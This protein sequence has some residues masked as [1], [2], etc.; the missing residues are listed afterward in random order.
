MRATVHGLGVLLASSALTLPALADD[1]AGA[2]NSPFKA[3]ITRTTHNIAHIEADTWE[4]VGYGVAYAYAED[5]ICMLAEDFVSVRGERSM[6]FGNEGQNELGLRSMD[7]LT[8]DVFFRSQVDLPALRAGLEQ[9]SPVNQALIAGYVAGYNRYLF[10]NPV[11][12]LPK[13]CRDAPWVRPITNDDMLRL[14]EKT[15]LLASSLAFA[16]AIAGAEPPSGGQASN[17]TETLNFPPPPEPSYGSNGWAFGSDVTADGKGLLIG[18]P[19]FPWEGP[20]RFWQMHVRGPDGYDVMGVGIAGTPLP[21]LGFNKDVAWTHTVTKARHFTAYMLQLAP[22]DPTSYIVDGEVVPMEETLVTIPMPVGEEPIERVMYST[23]FG[24]V[25]T[26]PQAGAVWTRQ[27]AFT[28][29]DA[30]T[31]NQRGMDAWLGIG[32]ASNVSEIETAI[33]ETL[34]IP[35]VNTIAADRNGNALHA[36]ITAVPNVS[37]EMAKECSTP[38]SALVAGQITLLDGT[39]SQCD[40]M[41]APT[42]ASVPGLLPASEQASRTRTDYVTNSNDSYW[43]SHAGEPYRELSP[44]LG[45]YKTELTLRSRSN[46]TETEATLAEA[47]IDHARAKELVFGNKV[48]AADMVVDGV[49]EECSEKAGLSKACEV[50]ADWDRRVNLD[51]KGAHLFLAFWDKVRGRKDLWA[52][53]FDPE[54]PVNTPRDLTSEGTVRLNLY[55]ALNE[56]GSELEE[57]GI[58]LDAPWGM[59]QTRMDGDETIPIHGATGL[60]GILNMQ[61][62]REVEGGLTPVHGSSYIQ[63]VGFDTDGPVADA[64]LSYSQSTNPASPFYA[65]QTRL[66]SAKDWHRLPF[67]DEEIEAARIGETVTISE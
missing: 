63:I 24:P 33:S 52:T 45:T 21:T 55:K 20:A 41:E 3:E 10:D 58:P 13:E 6:F 49:V 44:I 14:N 26:M 36:D 48:L 30:N 7:N 56:A 32:K 59:I 37:A 2:S 39:R 51:S 43:L 60:A 16:G 65:D 9:S 42:K 25:I 27:I 19:H 1:H 66:Y 29:R 12:T 11:S 18:N 22:D 50:L 47:K 31:G 23:R 4:G 61:E 34:G 28:L 5:N 8:S 53:P 17:G 57:K 38:L 35:W 64:V 54:D 62:S 15:M 40:W 46:Y 67:S